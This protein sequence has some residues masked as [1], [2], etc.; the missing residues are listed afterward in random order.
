[1][2]TPAPALQPAPKPKPIAPATPLTA[3]AIIGFVAACAI[4][5]IFAAWSTGFAGD[6]SY[7]AVI[8]RVL[9]LSYFDHPPLHQWILHATGWALGEGWQLKLPFVLMT[10]A[11]NAPLY[12]LTRRLLGERAALWTIFAFNAAP[13][14]VVW[15]DGVI[16]PDTPLFLF[17]AA[18]IW[19]VAEILFGPRRSVSAQLG[20][21]LAAGL[22]F[23]LSGLSK[24]SAAFAP[25]SLAGF[26]L[27]SPRHRFWLWHP[28][29]YLGAAVAFAV[30]SPVFIWNHQQQWASF[31]FQAGRSLPAPT[32]DLVA[33]KQMFDALGAQTALLSPWIGGPLIAALWSAGRN[34]GAGS[35][36]RFLLWLTGA[37]LL[38]FTVM[39]LMGQLTVPHWYNSAW[40]FAFPLLGGWLAAR[41]GAWLRLWAYASAGLAAIV[42]AAF[43]A[44][45]ALGPFWQSRD[46]QPRRDATQWSYDW[47]GLKE[48]PA[49]RE[50]G[51]AAPGFAIVENWRV[52]GKAGLA[53]GPR[54][55]VC[56]FTT[57]PRGLAYDCDSRSYLGQDALIVIPSEHAPNALPV[58][59][60]YFERLGPP[61]QVAEGRAG[62]TERIVTVVRGYKLQRPYEAPYGI[63]APLQGR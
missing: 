34:S 12:G 5:R 15:P 58:I 31:A 56:A 60:S 32:F 9:A 54:L 43:T 37:P 50:G 59:A 14:F 3:N 53:L 45:L 29:P 18:A 35:Q 16:L 49:Q 23:G 41:D 26:L 21:W 27:F 57:D 1:M 55:P 46:A 30:F 8:A 25:I 24:Y 11:L 7:T 61:Y 62:R 44:Y 47:N 19:I 33:I 20:L 36:E 52:G 42:F 13:Y 39:P 6:E 48:A 22:A 40:L 17:L 51:A 2:L 4:A 28:F 10:V 38:L 63:G